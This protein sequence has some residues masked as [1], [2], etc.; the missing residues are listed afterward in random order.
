MEVSYDLGRVSVI[1]FFFMCMCVCVCVCVCV[2]GIL[3]I[4][5]Y[6]ICASEFV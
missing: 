3:I 5:Y 6:M 4:S 2:A 1:A